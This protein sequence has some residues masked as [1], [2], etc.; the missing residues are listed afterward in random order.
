M[1]KA[2]TAEE[3]YLLSILSAQVSQLPCRTAGKGTE[4]EN[5]STIH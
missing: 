3:L 4:L 1:L 2:Q 5:Y